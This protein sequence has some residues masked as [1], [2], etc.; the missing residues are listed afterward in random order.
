MNIS[1]R[2]SFYYHADAN[3]LGGVLRLPLERIVSTH[4]SVSLAPG[5]GFSTSRHEH[6]RLDDHISA[7]AAY[8]YV[9]GADH[10]EHG[11]YRTTATAVVEGLNILEVVTADRIVAQVSLMHPYGHGP[12]EISLNGTQFI[13]LRVNGHLV[14]PRF[15]RRMFGV[16]IDRAKDSDA[17]QLIDLLRVAEVRHKEGEAMQRRMVDRLGERF[18]FADPATQIEQSGDALS[19]LVETADVEAPGEP[20][21]HVIHLPDFGNIFLGELRINRFAAE[22]IML[23]IEM[24]C[25]AQG[26]LTACSVK[27]NGRWAP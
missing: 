24:G 1:K 5:G 12:A 15:D 21:G 18:A 4:A 13:N 10:S 14:N 26:T 22:L 20:F 17:P 16:G 8:A 27:P 25:M 7:Q 2:P 3:A 19:T 11:G 23:R 9:S 6:Y